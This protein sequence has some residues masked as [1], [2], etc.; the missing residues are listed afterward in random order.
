MKSN[1]WSCSIQLYDALQKFHL[2]II[3]KGANNTD[4][5]VDKGALTFFCRTIA[6][7]FYLQADS[8]FWNVDSRIQR[9]INYDIPLLQLPE[10]ISYT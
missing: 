7:I 4:S 3:C 5:W 6:L 1:I 8:R 2:D 10:R 9:L